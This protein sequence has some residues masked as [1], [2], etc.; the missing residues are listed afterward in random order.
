MSSLL[1]VFYQSIY[2]EINSSVTLYCCSYICQIMSS[3]L[4][5]F[6]QSIYREINSSA[7]LYCCSYICQIMSSLLNVFY[8]SIYREINSSATLYCC[9][10]TCQSWV[11]FTGPLSAIG[12][13]SGYRCVFDCRSRGC[14]FDPGPV[15]YFRGDW[16]W[17]NFYGHS[18][19]FHWFIQEGLLSV[20]S[21]SL[22]TN[23]WLT[24]C[25]SLPRKK[26]G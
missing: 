7:T 10:N 20:T 3:L 24:A 11:L 13:V 12:N 2:R 17:N 9:S 26:C 8:Q 19:P 23:Y 6:Y 21:E 16:S 25:S 22:C 4:N 1:N 18:P 15:P 14:E 5:V